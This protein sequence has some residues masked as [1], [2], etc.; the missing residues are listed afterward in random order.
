MSDDG[1]PLPPATSTP[2]GSRERNLARALQAVAGASTPLSR[3]D[4]AGVLGVTRATASSLVEALITAGVVVESAEP[5]RNPR[6]RP[7]RGLTV[8]TSGPSGL[9]LEVNVDYLA[10]ALV[11][12]SGTLRCRIITPAEQRG[13]PV[14]DVV[15]DL[16]RLAG[17]ARTAGAREGLHMAGA[18]LAVPGLVS[19][20]DGRLLVAPNLGWEDVSVVQLLARE[21]SLAGL[22]LD[23]DNEANLAALGELSTGASGSTFLHVSGEVGVGAG[24]VV[25]GVLMR[26]QHG[27]GGE[28]GHVSVD[29]HGPPCR[30]GG[31]GCLETYAG[32]EAILLAAGLM[33]GVV[34]TLSGRP[35]AEQLVNLARAGE[36]ALMAALDQ[37]AEALGAALTTAVNL[38]DLDTVVL[39]GIYR[40]LAPWLVEPVQRY[41]RTRVVGGQ[42]ATPLVR[43]SVL[44]A[45]AAVIGAAG[46]VV[47]RVL[48]SPHDLVKG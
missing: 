35:T 36:P 30:C 46:E 14:G 47:R 37:A 20:G 32:Q 3:A 10:V 18:V 13:R 9:G 26:G 23:C 25:D 1:S 19:R 12:L 7:G 31:R 48:A 11:D 8:A 43:P 16:A 6:G 2:P 38:L 39:G 42:W 15:A 28:L 17:T 21:P 27:F 44:G 33:S 41:L 45:D 24:L 5:L 29:P 40:D 34:T 4:V 22:R